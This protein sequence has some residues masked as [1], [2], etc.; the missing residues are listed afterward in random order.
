MVLASDF[1][2]TP[3]LTVLHDGLRP[4]NASL[5]NT[6]LSSV[7]LTHGIHGGN[8]IKLELVVLC[9]TV[10]CVV[11]R[12]ILGVTSLRDAVPSGD[13]CYLYLKSR[14]NKPLSVGCWAFES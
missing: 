14:P 11:E 5:P 2:L 6:P 10:S 4:G 8:R 1:W 12:G 9:V 13:G 7:T 3:C